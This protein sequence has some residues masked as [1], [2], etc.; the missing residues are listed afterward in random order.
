[1]FFPAGGVRRGMPTELRPGV[2]LLELSGVNAY[3]VKDGDDLVLVDTGTPFDAGRIRSAVTEAGHRV[4]DIDRVLI[5]HYDLD[6][7]GGFGR[8]DLDSAAVFAA[9]PDA[10]YLTKRRSPPLD[11]HKGALQRA[12]RFLLNAP[13]EVHRVE[14]GDHIGSF[15][16]YRTPGHTPGHVAYVSE[17]LSVA[18]VGDLVFE[19]DGA[20]TASPWLLSYDTDTVNESIHDFADREPAVECVCPGHG[21]PFL[22][23]GAVRLAELGQRI[24][25]REEGVTE[26]TA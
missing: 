13:P 5:T 9:T 22:K 8:L 19:E 10:D 2:W 15:V 11:N 20:F 7:V 25:D 3:L 14:D 21:L 4:S 18:F 16:A 26:V 17:E 12:T 24:E 1:M 23:N 6:H